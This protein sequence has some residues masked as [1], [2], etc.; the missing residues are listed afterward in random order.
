MDYEEG[1][2]IEICK[3][4]ER[5]LSGPQ[6]LWAFLGFLCLA[7][8][9]EWHFEQCLVKKTP[10]RKGFRSYF[11]V[12]QL[13]DGPSG[14]FLGQQQLGPLLQVWFSIFANILLNRRKVVGVEEVE[15]DH[16][17]PNLKIRSLYPHK[18]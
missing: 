10:L 15:V 16:Q 12:L 8:E 18:T 3:V 7:L 6:T 5:A 9:L 1:P 11:M 2:F 4:L 13:W 17:P 14:P